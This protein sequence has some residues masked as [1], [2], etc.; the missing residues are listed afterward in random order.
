MLMILI[1]RRRPF[2]PSV[3]GISAS[4][5][6]ELNTVAASLAHAKI[7]LTFVYDIRRRHSYVSFN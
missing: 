5:S 2:F 6:I 1:R 4:S 3:S 7:Y